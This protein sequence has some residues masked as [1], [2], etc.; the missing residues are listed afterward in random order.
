MK[1]QFYFVDYYNTIKILH[2][3]MR[4]TQTELNFFY[5]SQY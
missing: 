5:N 3:D 4:V 2:A 1:M